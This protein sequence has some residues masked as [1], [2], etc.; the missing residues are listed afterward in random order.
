VRTSNHTGP[1][2]LRTGWFRSETSSDGEAQQIGYLFYFFSWRQKQSLASEILCFYNFIF[3]WWKKSKNNF[4]YYKAPLVIL[5]SLRPTVRNN[6]AISHLTLCDLCTC[7]TTIPL[8]DITWG[9]AFCNWLYLTKIIDAVLLA[10]FYF[11]VHVRPWRRFYWEYFGFFLSVVIL[12]KVYTHL[13]PHFKCKIGPT[14][15][16]V[17]AVSVLGRNFTSKPTLIWTQSK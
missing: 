2:S 9:R 14:I 15:W 4:T 5:H 11:C 13:S 10:A 8:R 3:R 7:Y 17:T 12:P 6:F 1:A 16:R